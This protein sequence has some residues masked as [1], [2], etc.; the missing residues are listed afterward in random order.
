MVLEKVIENYKPLS[1]I[2]L[3]TVFFI[4]I[5]II[6]FFGI[7]KDHVLENWN[8][9]RT[10]PFVLP[11]AG[12]IKREP[13]ETIAEA[14]KKNLNKVLWNIVNKFLEVLMSPI[15][16]I[17]SIFMKLLKKVTSVLNGIRNQIAIMRNLMFKLFE[18][19][20]MRLQNGV[21]TMTFFF[22]K[23]R[24]SMKRSYGLMNVLVYAIEHSFL[25]FESLVKSPLGKFG[26]LAETMGLG[27]SMFAFG[28]AG[29]PMWHGALCF[30]PD[31]PIV[32]NNRKIEL[33]KNIKIGDLLEDN[34]KVVAVIKSRTN[35]Y[36]Y[37]LP[38]NIKVSGDHLIFYNGL[39]ERVNDISPSKESSSLTN[40]IVCLVTQNGTIKLGEYLFKDY[41][42]THDKTTNII[43]RDKVNKKLNDGYIPHSLYY[44]YKNCKCFINNNCN[45]LLI[46]F[47]RKTPL[48]SNDIMGYIEISPGELDIYFYNGDILSGNVLVY[49]YKGKQYKRVAN[50]KEAV[51]IGK[52]KTPFI[53][54]ITKSGKIKTSHN[55]IR[56]F[57][58]CSDPDLEDNIDTYVDS[59]INTHDWNINYKNIN[60]KNIGIN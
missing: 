49:Q 2:L 33:I 35:Q 4:I 60:Y 21:A 36:L 50:I 59:V 13:G 45:D 18:D 1:K 44:K 46:G 8:Y 14:S 27:A 12:F 55:I 28:A 54:L 47:C 5:Y 57:C 29:V 10:N 37:E 56:D 48:I 6:L 52:N 30:H 58:E 3:Y 25:F 26:K 20:Y 9:Y 23:L 51:Y 39:W 42:D 43:I 24:E 38:G 32:L 31:T 11:F 41:L 7:L 53:H 22:L 16:P 19:M 34:N 15:Y 40:N 17:I